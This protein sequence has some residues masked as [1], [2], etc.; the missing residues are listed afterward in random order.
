MVKKVLCISL[1]VVFAAFISVSQY[2][3]HIKP[4]TSKITTDQKI[5]AYVKPA[6][7]RIVEGYTITWQYNAP[8]NTYLSTDNLINSYL[9]KMNNKSDVLYS[10]T[11]AIINPDGY[12]VTNAHVVEITKTEDAKLI[13]EELQYISEDLRKQFNVTFD[14]MYDFAKKY[15]KATSF[16]RVHKVI[17][18]GKSDR[19]HVVL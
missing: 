16:Q 14:V 17:L 11:G 15:I 1:I 3:V 6:V 13:D 2:L 4:D 10:G 12:V 19:S 18:P 5:A 9:K 7:V 8:S